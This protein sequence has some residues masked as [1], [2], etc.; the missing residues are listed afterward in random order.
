MSTTQQPERL[1]KLLARAG[2][3]SRR[4]AESL[5][6][7]GR[8]SINGKPATLGE[9]AIFGQ[10]KILV[11]DKSLE[12]A[13]LLVYLRLYKPRG[14]LTA[15]SDDTGRPI[16]TE[17]LTDIPERVF[18]VG[19]LDYETEGLLLLTNDG[20]LANALMHPSFQI[21]RTY[22]AKV[23]GNPTANTLR[24]LVDGVELDDGL[25]QAIHVEKLHPTPAGHTWIEIT[26]T[27][28]RNR[29]V[30]RMCEAIGHPVLRLRRVRF[31]NIDIEGLQ[32]GEYQPIGENAVRELRSLTGNPLPMPHAKLKPI[33]K[34]K[35]KPKAAKPTTDLDSLPTAFTTKRARKPS[36]PPRP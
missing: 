14:Y 3:T 22:H 30:R 21:Q 10:D 31:G 2:I 27:E 16:I 13:E 29:E 19:R 1:Q 18:P 35:P 9:K 12:P 4:K 8:V 34:P 28:G 23:R 15:L 26:L 20:E 17:L 33:P 5:I 24:Q 11:D 36:Q 32:P 6:R 25:A 7:A